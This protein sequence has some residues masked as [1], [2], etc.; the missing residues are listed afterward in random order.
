MNRALQGA[1]SSGTLPTL[2]PDPGVLA[3]GTR[4]TVTAS[5]RIRI[6]FVDDEPPVLNLLQ[7]LVRHAHPEWESSYTDRGAKALQLMEQHPFDVVV[8]DMRM[9]EMTGAELLEQVRDR[10]PRTARIILSG[11]ADHGMSTRSLSAAHQYLAK[12]FTL[13]ALQ[14]ALKHILGVRQYVEN[15]IVQQAIG[16]L[17]T[18]RCS[19][20]V[21]EQ[22]TRTITAPNATYDS[23][24]SLIAQDLAL[25]AKSLQ[26]VHSAFFGAP[27]RIL[28]AKEGP[29]ALGLNLLRALTASNQ[30]ALAPTTAE[31]GGLRLDDAS[32]HSVLVGLRATR[33]LSMER[34][35]P[36]AVKLAFTAGML[37]GIGRLI[38]ATLFPERH[39]E[40]LQRARAGEVP[41]LQAE[42]ESC[43][44]NHS[45]AGAYLLGLWGLPHDVISIVAHAHC[46]SAV[47]ATSLTPLTA[48]HVAH[49]FEKTSLD[50]PASAAPPLD[51]THLR[52]LRIDKAKLDSWAQNTQPSPS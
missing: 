51:Q 11:Y 15:P 1:V 33:I 18:L 13:A 3:E 14:S 26:I 16:T 12:P 37:S 45:Q 43:G 19:P 27:R 49:Q 20:S 21:H 36:D 22:L 25:T 50:L 39:L 52:T 9:P 2:R 5:R 48:V 38:L 17:H 35:T 30:L 31:I 42:E 4:L 23:L 6:L 44:A 24:G 28:L 40:A 41:L 10:F 34:V 32:H 8:S 46:P 7:T 47:E 29:R